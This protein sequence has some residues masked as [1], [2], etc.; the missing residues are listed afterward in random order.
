MMVLLTG[1]VKEGKPVAVKLQALEGWALLV[2]AL[3]EHAPAQLS[4]VMH[5]V[6]DSLISCCCLP[7]CHG[8][9]A[10]S[11]VLQLSRSSLCD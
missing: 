5:Q 4:S 2:Q 3:L 10:D 7:L 9:Q 1:A 6:N 8:A 11:L